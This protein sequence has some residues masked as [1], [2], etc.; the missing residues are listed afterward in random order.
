MNNRWWESAG[1]AFG[2]LVGAIVA[3]RFDERM[4]FVAHANGSPE[5]IHPS[6]LCIAGT[7]DRP[8]FQQEKIG[9]P[10]VA[11]QCTNP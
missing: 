8:P 6:V 4:A 2:T 1:I 3:I 9:E 5:S 7:A 10:T 11:C